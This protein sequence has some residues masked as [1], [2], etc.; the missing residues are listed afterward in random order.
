MSLLRALYVVEEQTKSEKLGEALSQTRK[1]VEA[2]ISLSD[3]LRKHPDIFNELYGAMVEA[4]ELGGILE[5][6]LQRVADQLEKDDSLRRQVKSAMIYPA[7]IGGFA[8]AVLLALVTFLVPVFEKIFKDFGGDLP[9]IT[10]FTVFLSHL[11]TRQWYI[12]FGSIFAI[13]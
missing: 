2:G 11:F 3:A 10:K 9:A 12:L 1:D 6:T 7:L 4:G 5:S 8:C 13:V